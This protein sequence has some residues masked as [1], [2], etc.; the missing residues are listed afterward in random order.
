VD[1][2]NK[3]IVLSFRG[4]RSIRNWITN[5]VFP[6]VPTTIC[7]DCVASQGFWS[8]WLE[9]EKRVLATI[10]TARAQYPDYRVIATGHSLGGALAALGAGVLRSQGITVDLYT[11]GAPKIGLEGISQFLTNTTYGN[12][13]RVAHKKDPVPKLPPALLGYRHISPEY[14]VTSGNGVEV[15]AADITVLQGTL[16]LKGNEGDFGLD[17]DAHNWYFEDIS[18]CEGEGGVEVKL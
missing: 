4:S 12:S 2:T 11:Y 17:G 3:L 5:V 9:A 18:G 6:T 1:S 7:A 15:T 14:Y 13:F 16:N 10:A 8:S